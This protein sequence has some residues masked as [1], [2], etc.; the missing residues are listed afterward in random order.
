MG[1]WASCRDAFGRTTVNDKLFPIQSQRGAKPHPLRIPWSVAELAYSVYSGLYGRDQSLE[2]LAERG[3][4]GPGEMDEFLPDWRERCD[5]IVAL[6]QRCETETKRTDEWYRYAMRLRCPK[7][8]HEKGPIGKPVGI[9]ADG[10][11]EVWR[12]PCECHEDVAALR[13]RCEAAAHNLLDA[14]MLIRRLCRCANVPEIKDSALEWLVR[15]GLQG[16]PLRDEG[17][18]AIQE[19][20][21]GAEKLAFSQAEAVK[22]H[23]DANDALQTRIRDLE[24]RCDGAERE[25]IALRKLVRKAEKERDELEFD[26]AATDL[27]EAKSKVS[28]VTFSEND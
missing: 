4:F 9:E 11:K 13:Q 21:D 7:C 28:P 3:G 24:A 5:E 2:R 8:N 12:C 26:M 25:C 27:E 22:S 17:S 10:F 14:S 23:S 15:K 16:S 18:V 20:C 19:R 1:R 6:Y